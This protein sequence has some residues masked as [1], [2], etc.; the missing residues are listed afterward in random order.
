MDKFGM[1]NSLFKTK[2]QNHSLYKEWALL[3]IPCFG[4]TVLTYFAQYYLDIRTFKKE[5]E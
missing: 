2:W 3:T 4:I 1:Q 5:L